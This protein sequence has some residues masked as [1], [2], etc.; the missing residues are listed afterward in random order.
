MSALGPKPPIACQV[1][2]I[3]VLAETDIRIFSLS[4]AF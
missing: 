3:L 4:H 2:A 1:S